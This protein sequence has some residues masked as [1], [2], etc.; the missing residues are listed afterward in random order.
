MPLH[1]EEGDECNDIEPDIGDNTLEINAL[2]SN[3]FNPRD[4]AGC[5][6]K[7]I[8]NVLEDE[9]GQVRKPVI[10][11]FDMVQE[12]AKDKDLSEIK[13]KLAQ[14]SGTS[15]MFKH[16]ILLDNVLYYVSNP[17]DEP[18]RRLYVPEHKNQLDGNTVKAHATDLR[19]AKID[20]WE[21][22]KDK[23]KS[24]LRQSTFAVPKDQS[25]SDESEEVD[26]EPVM[27]RIARRFRKERQSSSEEEDIPLMELAKRLRKNK[28]GAERTG[29]N[30]SDSDTEFETEE[31][32]NRYEKSA[33]R[34][35]YNEEES[36]SEKESVMDIDNIASKSCSIESARS[37]TSIDDR[38]NK[39]RKVVQRT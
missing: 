2:N 19:L 36:T 3:Q 7:K 5:D 27:K 15:A 32:S 33:V 35:S 6:T 31:R 17:D 39:R 20:D 10:D 23:A 24:R 13:V 4:F 12:Q 26:S 28:M 30:D 34:E 8:N 1:L 22:P 9:S 21:I 18:T 14:G 25:T 29:V 37:Y 38:K 11:G 16:Y